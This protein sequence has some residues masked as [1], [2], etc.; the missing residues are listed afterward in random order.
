MPWI[1]LIGFTGLY[2]NHAKLINKVLYISAYDEVLFDSAPDRR[3]ID[4][5][6]A[7][8]IAEALWGRKY[9]GSIK[10]GIYH[11]RAVFVLEA[12]KTK[13]IVARDTGHYW[14]KSKFMRKTYSPRGDLLDSKVYWGRI[15][16]I[17]HTDGWVGGG[18]GSWLADIAAAAMVI[19]GISGMVLFLYPRIRRLKKHR[20]TMKKLN[21]QDHSKRD[22][23]PSRF[24]I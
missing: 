22:T 12:N 5:Q 16:K 7:V 10:A 2:L 9:K 21:Q 8:R 14:L 4:K 11:K 17:I 19:F 20:L 18:L 1:I 15:F 3:K 24:S 23:Q 6:I 13:L